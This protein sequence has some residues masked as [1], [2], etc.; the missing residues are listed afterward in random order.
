MKNKNDHIHKYMR[1][2]LGKSRKIVYKEIDGVPKRFLEKTPGYEI[3][4]CMIPG[5][6]H[7][8]TREMAIGQKSICWNCGQE[9]ILNMEN[10]TLKKPTHEECRKVRVEVA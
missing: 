9:M 8:K 1:A 6:T 7:Y 10:T 4:R 5:C 3:F 2:F